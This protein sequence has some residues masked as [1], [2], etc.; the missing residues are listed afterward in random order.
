M[1]IFH[2][3]T[4]THFEGYPRYSDAKFFSYDEH[5]ESIEELT[6]TYQNGMIALRDL[7][8]IFGRPAELSVN[9]FNTSICYKTLSGWVEV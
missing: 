8:K 4:V 2:S 3:I 1:K 9:R 6:M 7:E 5:G